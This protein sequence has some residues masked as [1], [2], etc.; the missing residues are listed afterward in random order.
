[1]VLPSAKQMAPMP[2]TFIVTNCGKS[3]ALK[4]YFD[5]AELVCKNDTNNFYG[6]MIDSLGEGSTIASL[7]ALQPLD[8]VQVAQQCNQSAVVL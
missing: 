2:M 1:M 5:K 6:L 3:R 4:P 7:P 8:Y